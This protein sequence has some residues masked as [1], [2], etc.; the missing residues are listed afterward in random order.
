MVTDRE[1]IDAAAKG[2]RIEAEPFKPLAERLG[3]SQDEV[4]DRLKGMIEAG[5]VRRFA[6]SVR[7]QPIGYLFN[8]MIL[9]RTD[10]ED[11]DRIGQ[12]ACS[13]KAVSHCYQRSHPDGDPWCLYIMAH[14]RDEARLDDV[15]EE[16]RNL[17]GV[18]ALEICRSIEE[19]KKTSLS[20]V[21]SNVKKLKR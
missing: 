16:I 11:L 1:L 12:A 15:I 21:T 6:A 9:A 8:A 10:E 2:L 18:R 4:I 20:G 13:I 17:P 14:H 7:H 3:L 5:K 19:L